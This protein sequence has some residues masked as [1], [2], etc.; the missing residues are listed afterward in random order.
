[1]HQIR[2]SH[3]LLSWQGRALLV[4]G[5]KFEVVEPFWATSVIASVAKLSDLMDVDGFIAIYQK[6]RDPI[7]KAR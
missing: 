7:R 6:D 2:R 1:M 3:L 4:S 5:K